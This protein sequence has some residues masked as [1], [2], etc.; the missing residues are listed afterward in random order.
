LEKAAADSASTLSKFAEVEK[1]VTAVQASMT[2]LKAE[3][4]KNNGEIGKTLGNI[5]KLLETLAPKADSSEQRVA[6]TD[7][8]PTV[9]K[10]DD[11]VVNKEA[12]AKD[13]HTAMKTALQTPQNP[14][15]YA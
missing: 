3:T 4:E 15:Q 2:E 14:R 12:E 5:L 10:R 6:R 13:A 7:L 1:T 9:F 11:T 8:N